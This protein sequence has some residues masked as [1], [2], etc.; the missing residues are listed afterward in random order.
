VRCF[1]MAL[2]MTSSWRMAATS[3]S[4]LAFPATAFYFN[5]T[6]PIR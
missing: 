4:F 2:R 5:P 3:A 1:S 6:L